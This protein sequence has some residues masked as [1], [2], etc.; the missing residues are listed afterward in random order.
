MPEKFNLAALLAEVSEPDTGR[1]Q[2]EYISLD[3]IDSD[4]NNFYTLTDIDKL[5]DN[6]SLCGLQQ[7]IRVRE[8]ENGRYMIVSGHRRR[9]ALELLV[10][11]GYEKFQEAPCIVER[12]KVSSSLRQLRLIYANSNTR[13][14]SAAEISEQAVQVEKLLY[15]LKEEGYDF[16]GRMRDHVAQAMAVSKSKLARLKVIRD[17]LDEEW[18]PAFQRGELSESVAYALARM[19]YS[20]Q[21]TVYAVRGSNAKSLTEDGLQIYEQRMSAIDKTVCKHNRTGICVNTREMREK[22]CK[23]RWCDPCS[24]RCCYDCNNLRT[25]GKACVNAQAKKKELKAVEQ[26]AERDAKELQAERDRSRI[27][28]IRSVYMRVGQA[29]Q[30]AGKTVEDIFTAQK[31]FLTTSAVSDFEALEQGV[32]EIHAVTP[33]PFGYAFE[34]AS[35]EAIISVADCLGCSIDWLLGRTDC[36]DIAKESQQGKVWQTGNP[37]KPGSYALVFCDNIYCGPRTEIWDWDGETWYQ[38]REPY[39]EN[40]D[41][42]I[43][44]WVPML[45]V[46][47]AMYD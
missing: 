26:K 32:K 14:L 41:G 36:P 31:R 24:S 47:E 42:K 5:A 19:S 44:G 8:Q 35:A 12:D 9:A 17:G 27:D 1:E 21:A 37:E 7:P 28:L 16:P 11:D 45:D 23:D 39:D 3:L 40:I 33:L 4:P 46:T 6:I 25:C 10:A 18:R 38:F 29:R 34:A 20:H 43:L 2:I 13:T 15:Q 30:S 22:S